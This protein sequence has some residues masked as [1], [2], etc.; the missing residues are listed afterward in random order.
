MEQIKHYV[1]PEHTNSLYKEESIS[2]IGLTREIAQKINELIDAYNE[3]SKIDLEWKQTQEGYI[4]K[5]VLFMKDNLLNSIQDLLDLVGIQLIDNTVKT[6]MAGKVDKNGNEQVTLAMLSQEVKQALTGG[7]VAVVGKDAVNTTNIVNHAVSENKL[8]MSLIPV[9]MFATSRAAFTTPLIKIKVVDGSF[10]YELNPEYTFDIN[11]ITPST[12][13]VMK[14]SEITLATN[15]VH[16]ATPHIFYDT[17]TKVLHIAKPND[18]NFDG[19]LYLG[20]AYD[21]AEY[22]SCVIPFEY[23][24]TIYTPHGS[25]KKKTVSFLGDSLT[26]YVGYIPEGNA[27][28]YNGIR[29]GVS[30]VNETWWK[31]VLNETG[32]TLNINNSYSGAR[33]ITGRNDGADG[34][35][36]ATALDNGSDPDIIFVFMGFND[37]AGNVGIGT[38]DGKGPVPV[39]TTLFREGYANMLVNILKKYKTSKVYAMTLTPYQNTTEDI[40]SPESNTKGTFISEYNDAIREIAKAFN[41]EIIDTECCGMTNYNASIYMGDYNSEDGT[42]LHP[43]AEGHKLIADCVI[44]SLK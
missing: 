42:F 29:S 39:S 19:M 28:H 32:Y 37:A 31:R 18:R 40:D 38:Y 9:K 12:I 35:T 30:N 23:E 14:R 44:K 26:S 15:E 24:G 3:L 21:Y 41:V 11:L 5:G 20:G 34:V 27:F 33:V 10:V 17:T 43:N 13:Y 36:R 7:S 2:S 22:A 16:T 25:F 8:K 1:L 6:R 4:R